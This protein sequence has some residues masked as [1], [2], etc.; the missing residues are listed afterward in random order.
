M[1]I[2]LVQ[3][4]DI[5]NNTELIGFYTDLKAATKDIKELHSEIEGIEELELREY[6]GTTG[7]QFNTEIYE[8]DYLKIFGY[9]IYLEDLEFAIE[10]LKK[11]EKQNGKKSK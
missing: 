9:I 1:K 3:T 4:I 8:T 11:G 5:W 6:A 7:P 2:Y 10:Q